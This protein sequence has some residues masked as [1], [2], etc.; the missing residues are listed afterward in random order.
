MLV[1]MTEVMKTLSE[2]TDFAVIRDMMTK[3]GYHVDEPRNKRYLEVEISCEKWITF[4]FDKDGS[5]TSVEL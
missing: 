2:M 3:V 1:E 5:L 4:N